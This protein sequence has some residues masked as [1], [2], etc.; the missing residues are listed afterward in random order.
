[1]KSHGSTASS[2][3]ARWTKRSGST[4]SPPPRSLL[5]VGHHASG[6]AA[7]RSRIAAVRRSPR[8]SSVWRY[9]SR[10]LST[11]TSTPGM[12]PSARPRAARAAPRAGADS[13]GPHAAERRGPRRRDHVRRQRGRRRA[14]ARLGGLLAE[15][16]HAGKA[17]HLG[18]DQT[19]RPALPE[20]AGDARAERPEA[21]VADRPVHEPRRTE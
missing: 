3:Y 15:R 2:G 20:A 9:A 21:P 5:S 17:R 7:R 6:S 14:A 11:S 10:G 19:D 13:T 4:V 8:E 1:M 18:P 16:R 12:A